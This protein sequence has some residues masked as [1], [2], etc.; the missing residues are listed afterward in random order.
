MKT[1]PKNWLVK[2][3]GERRKNVQAVRFERRERRF[4]INGNNVELSLDALFGF[5]FRPKI[6]WT[7]R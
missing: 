1:K 6:P 2:E 3:R 4:I 7:Q 5:E